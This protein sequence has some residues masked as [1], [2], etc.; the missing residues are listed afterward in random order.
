MKSDGGRK[1]ATLR[2]LETRGTRTNPG[3]PALAASGI[4]ALSTDRWGRDV[5]FHDIPGPV[6]DRL[7]GVG[8]GQNDDGVRIKVLRRGRRGLTFFSEPSVVRR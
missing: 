2:V 3:V 6:F 1:K 8:R 4:E 5:S 7:P